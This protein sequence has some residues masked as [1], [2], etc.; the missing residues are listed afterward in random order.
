M[1]RR[2]GTGSQPGNQAQGLIPLC[3]VLGVLLVT[4]WMGAGTALAQ[5]SAIGG[6]VWLDRD[7]DGLT[8]G[9][10]GIVGVTVQ[11]Y[12]NADTFLAD[13]VTAS[14][15]TYLFN[16]LAAGTFIVRLD[17]ATLPA[18]TFATYESDGFIDDEIWVDVVADGSE[19]GIDWGFQ[20]SGSISG[21]VFDDL[22]ADGIVDQGENGLGGATLTLTNLT[23]GFTFTTTSLGDG[24][25]YLGGFPAL[26]Y[27][28]SIDPASLPGFNAVSEPDGV[29]DHQVV[30]DLAGI[31]YLTGQHFGFNGN[32][33]IEG[34]I[35]L[36]FEPI[37]QIDPF[38]I[39]FV[40][41]SIALFDDQDVQLGTADTVANGDYRFDNLT[42]GTYKVWVLSN[43]L[44][45]G[46]LHTYDPNGFLD[47]QE[48]VTVSGGEVISDIDF[49]FAGNIDVNSAVIYDVNGDG[50]YDNEDSGL[51]GVTVTLTDLQSSETSQ[52]TTGSSGGF[53]WGRP[54]S[55]FVPPRSRPVHRTGG[56]EPGLGPRRHAGS[57]DGAHHRVRRRHLRRQLLL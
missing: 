10:P 22:N 52:M 1:F 57:P 6:Q 20:G 3:F 56:T 34:R 24:G 39:G 12:D 18:D 50:F 11:L 55:G 36:D 16:N 4:Q 2:I 46:L 43:T 19:L 21:L 29:I 47:R 26:S 25:Y 37:N 53:L 33:V 32:G 17:L 42:P 48:T 8:T 45:F 35:F 41:V 49:G 40:G 31:G 28:L 15:G 13:V 14:D 7:G 9:E 27:T 30:V 38:D 5:T 23:Y 44:P 51:A 54:L